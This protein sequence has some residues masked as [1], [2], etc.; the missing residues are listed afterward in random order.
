MSLPLT[1]VMLLSFPWHGQN[2]DVSQSRLRI[3]QWSLHTTSDRFSGR[4]TCRLSTR[5][6]AY[7]RQALIVRM[8]SH[9]D[10]AGAVYRIDGGS[11]ILASADAMELAGHG[12]SLNQDDLENPSGGLVLIPA[13]RAMDAH[14]L[15]IETKP[16]TAPVRVDISGF[17]LALRAAQKA[18]CGEEAFS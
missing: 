6:I 4:M 17:G 15:A 14:A 1:L 13:R 10:A 18:G 9:V 2:P 3:G 16:N 5:G 12:A 7:Q 11:P 8:G